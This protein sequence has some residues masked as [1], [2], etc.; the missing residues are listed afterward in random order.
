MKKEKNAPR[1]NLSQNGSPEALTLDNMQGA[2][3][4]CSF[5]LGVSFFKFLAEMFGQSFNETWKTMKSP[6]YQERMSAEKARADTSQNLFLN[7]LT[8]SL[9]LYK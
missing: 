5:L 1:R 9:F 8:P 7:D 2:F 3:F 4:L 6:N